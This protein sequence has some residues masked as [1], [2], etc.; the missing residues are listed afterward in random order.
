ML[1][2]GLCQLSEILVAFSGS[3]I[4]SGL[5]R[6]RTDTIQWNILERYRL[7]RQDVLFYS[8]LDGCLFALLRW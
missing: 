6:V 7:W 2:D 3:Q 4:R 1:T 8:P 5:K